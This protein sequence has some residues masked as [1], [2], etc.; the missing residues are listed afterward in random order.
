MAYAV[1]ADR[2][3]PPGPILRNGGAR[4]G[5]AVTIAPVP[6]PG[7][8]AALSGAPGAAPGGAPTVAPAMP[9]QTM[10][11][12]AYAMQQYQEPGDPFTAAAMGMVNAGQAREEMAAEQAKAEQ[13][14]ELLKDF[15]DLQAAV[16]TQ[17]LDLGSALAL[18]EQRTAK[19]AAEA[20]KQQII[21]YLRASDDGDIAEAFENGVL[22]EDGVAAAVAAKDKPA[23]LTSDQQ[24]LIQI[25]E[26]RKAAGQP[27]L[28]LEEHQAS[29]AGRGTNAF[30][31]EQGI[32][33]QY[34]NADPLK[35]YQLIRNG[36]E[37]IRSSGTL[38]SGAGDVS[39]IFAYMKMLDPT[40]VVREGEFATAQNTAGI[41]QTI[42]N[43]YNQAIS[44]VRLGDDQRAEF[45]KA[46]DEIYKS[47]VGN[48][49]ALN[50]Q[51]ATRAAEWDIAPTFIVK[52]ETYEPWGDTPA[53]APDGTAPAEGAP[54]TITDD[55]GYD[56]LPIG[57]EFI[58][59]DGV[60]RT[61]VAD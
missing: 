57:T 32:N 35:S 1:E 36:Y 14:A 54:V 43:L 33:Q 37:K 44:G 52:P 30:N 7:R 38:K 2:P 3:S 60:K 46:A 17:T 49:E 4:P 47:A 22:D 21:T 45:I 40:S 31:M 16:K 24:E 8:P 13:A 18:G 34:T 25:N 61:K 15:P 10:A 6:M 56:A 48:L 23:D 42:T 39:M 29:K 50:E 9:A 28:S 51:Y 12:I 20:R 53:P 19:A 5:R 58:G 26:E 41:P 27:P 59:P 55:A 11:P